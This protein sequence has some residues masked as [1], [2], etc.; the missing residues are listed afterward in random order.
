MLTGKPAFVMSSIGL[1][2]C[3]QAPSKNVALFT[4]QIASLLKAIIAKCNASALEKFFKSLFLKNL[5]TI[6]LLACGLL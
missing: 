6:R 3:R 4:V 2:K 1:F 5:I